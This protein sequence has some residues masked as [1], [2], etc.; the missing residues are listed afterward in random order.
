MR[1]WSIP[2]G[3]IFGVDIRIDF[4]FLLLLAFVAFSQQAGALE[5]Q[6]VARRRAG[7]HRLWLGGAARTRARPGGKAFRSTS[8][9]Y[10]ADADWRCHHFRR[11]PARSAGQLAARCAHCGGRPGGQFCGRGNC[12]GCAQPRDSQPAP[13]GR[14]PTS[15]LPTCRTAFCGRTCGW[16][17]SIFYP[18]IPWTEGAYC[19]LFSAVPWTRCGP[20]AAPSAWAE[21]LPW[22][23]SWL[24]C[25][26]W[27]RT[28]R[29]AT[30]DGS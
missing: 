19:A 30:P 22:R 29:L 6:S 24:A 27:A 8:A 11:D 17:Y 12:R 25:G 1:S 4:S 23:L 18:H 13:P 10:R 5:R 7:G 28:T 15:P 26:A 14:I 16:G 9:G 2:A 20:R 3:R 21:G